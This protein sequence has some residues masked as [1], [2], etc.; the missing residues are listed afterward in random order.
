MTS[1]VCP[2]P[3][4]CRAQRVSSSDVS[5]PDTVTS[6][7]TL[8]GSDG[9][10]NVQDLPVCFPRSGEKRTPVLRLQLQQ[11]VVQTFHYF[12]HGIKIEGIDGVGLLVVVPV[13]EKRCISYHDS[14]VAMAP[15]GVIV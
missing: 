1:I 4:S 3:K 14:P 8:H 12:C 10:C 7:S 6:F 5:S 2:D 11:R 9:P 13:P 15:E